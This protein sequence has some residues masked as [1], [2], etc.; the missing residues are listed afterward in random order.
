[1]G[2]AIAGTATPKLELTNLGNIPNPVPASGG[3]Y[4]I[5]MRDS[6]ADGFSWGSQSN[7]LEWLRRSPKS[8]WLDTDTQLTIT[9]YENTAASS[10]NG[11]IT[12]TN[13]DATGDSQTVSISQAGFQQTPNQP[14]LAMSNIWTNPPTPKEGEVCTLYARIQNNGSGNSVSTNH[15]WYVDNTLAATSSVSSLAPGQTTTVNTSFTFDSAG[16]RAYKGIVQ[17]VSGESSTSNNRMEKSLQVESQVNHAPALEFAEVPPSNVNPGDT[18]TIKL[19]AAD[20]DGNL[21]KIA[22]DWEGRGRGTDVQEQ[23]AGNDQAV[24]FSHSYTGNRAVTFTATAY[25]HHDQAGMPRLRYSIIV[26]SP[27]FDT[28]TRAQIVRVNG[29]CRYVKYEGNPID[30]SMGA[31]VVSNTYLSVQG[32][33]PVAFT[34]NY[35]SFLNTEGNLGRGW[36]YNAYETY[37]QKLSSGDVKIHWSA[38]RHNRFNKDTGGAYTAEHISCQNDS[39]VKNADSSFTLTRKDRAIYQFDSEGR[40]LKLGNPRNQNLTFAY[41]QE[42]Q[43]QG[44]L[45]RVTEPVTGVYLQYAYNSDGL[46][47]TVSDPLGRTVTLAY[48]TDRNLVRITDP[49]QQVTEHSY[50]QYGQKISTVLVDAGGEKLALSANSYDPGGSGR[51]VEQEDANP[52]NQPI[53]FSYDYSQPGKIIV[54]VLGRENGKKVYTYNSDL[55]LLTQEDQLGNLAVQNI[56]T[57][58]RLTKTLDARNNPVEYTYDEHGNTDSIKDA[59]G[60]LTEFG[61][62]GE[63]NLLWTKD[64]DNRRTELR[65]ADNKLIEIIDPMNV[66][67]G[68]TTRYEYNEHGQ[69]TK[70]LHPEGGVTVYA[71][72]GGRV[73]SVTDPEQ[74]SRSFSYDAAGRVKTVTDAGQNTTVFEYDKLDR[75]T[76]IIDA[77][78]NSVEMRYNRRGDISAVKDANGNWMYRF[79]DDNGNLIRE[80]KPLNQVVRYEYDGEDRLLKIIRVVDGVERVTALEYDAKGRLRKTADP[81]L[82]SAGFEYDEA[83]NLAQVLDALNRPVQSF[84]YDEADNVRTRANAFDHATRFSHDALN[85]VTSIEDARGRI[86]QLDYD[87]SDRVVS[88]RLM[89]SDITVNGIS[90]Q[91]FDEDG[92][93]TH[94]FDPKGNH[95]QFIRNRNGKL[96][97]LRHGIEDVAHYGYNA[98][99]LLES[100]IN[101]R[102]QQRTFQYDKLGWLASLNDADGTIE[103]TYDANG[104]PRFVRDV[105]PDTTITR[106]YDALDRM[107]KYIDS[108]GNVLEYVYDEADNL[109]TLIYPDLREVHYSYDKADRLVKVVD[110]AQRETRYFYDANGRLEKIERPNATVLT[111]IYNQAGQ[112][113]RQKD[114]DANGELIRQYDFSYDEAEN[115]RGETVTPAREPFPLSA[116]NMSYGAYNRLASYNGEA[117]THD[118]D[119]NMTL[120][121][122]QD[123]MAALVFDSR[124][125]LIQA[126]NTVYQYDAED[127]RIA[128][129]MDG[130]TTRYVINPQPALSQVLVRTA[131]DGTQTYYVHAPGAGLIGQESGGVY[132][133]YHYDLR[134]SAVALSNASGT[135]TERFQYSAFAL[136][137]NRDTLPDTPFLYNGRDGVMTD[138]SGLYYMRARYYN[139]EVRRFVNQDVL[140]GSV[141]E[142]QTLNRYAYV[143]GQPVSYIDPFGLNVTPVDPNLARTIMVGG[144]T[145]YMTM[146]ALGPAG[147]CI[148]GGIAYGAAVSYVVA[149][150]SPTIGS[151]GNVESIPITSGMGS[152]LIHTQSITSQDLYRN[153][154]FGESIETGGSSSNNRSGS[155]K[156]EKHGDK[157]ALRKADNQLNTLKEKLKNTNGREATK[158]QNKINKIQKTA[159]NKVKGEEHTRVYKR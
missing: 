151:Y 157:N 80:E 55:Q 78:Q 64:A 41:Y 3:S 44:K 126:G 21:W 152:S 96:A 112:L 133:A 118:D 147:W 106:E 88:S 120:G 22:V 142:G 102:H 17:A 69:V 124:N 28:G 59:R 4:T 38:N 127:R 94:L 19:R 63:R 58:G 149:T 111:Y 12:F 36:G 23:D 70:I 122:L 135:V 52:A 67:A 129:T 79:Y 14:D 82:V 123:G 155:S 125:R 8:G 116:V 134:G 113:T 100:V 47:Q 18:F 84:S 37:L 95:T 6:Q 75:L 93:R 26:G 32:V 72:A 66:S 86:T 117:V 85:R 141:A 39:L 50:N 87:H 71:Y 33:L 34:L 62:D 45:Y 97:A 99:G 108:R 148:A 132:Q 9:V 107:R 16:S 60:N 68:K 91:V 144:A 77:L 2:N 121:P 83:D 35:N 143:T 65:Y 24:S 81:E 103:Y 46:L 1:M 131:P 49:E 73:A 98:R 119:G 146:L 114:A 139:P 29:V 15:S 145:T 159:K 7:D 5:T 57:N 51:I 43:H 61:Y 136:L 13:N 104:N 74:V 105:T 158:L 150:H 92:N 11:S 31:Q 137:V 53:R 40:L 20:P 76:K 128:V 30:P 115:I 56:Y 130:Q 110:W 153:V 42:G 154:M 48:D 10:R 109:R 138:A 156:N 89:D 54:T 25:D 90:T 140:L 27:N 101:A